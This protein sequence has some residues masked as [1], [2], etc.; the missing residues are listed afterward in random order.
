M[1]KK[2]NGLGLFGVGTW[3]DLLKSFYEVSLCTFYLHWWEY[4]RDTKISYFSYDPDTPVEGS[5]Q[6]RK[7]RLCGQVQYLPNVPDARWRNDF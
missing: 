3:T 7:C 6:H 2:K 1:A 5:Y 4:Y